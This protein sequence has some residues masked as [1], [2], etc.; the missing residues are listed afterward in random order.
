MK[1]RIYIIFVLCL[2]IIKSDAALKIEPLKIHDLKKWHGLDANSPTLNFQFINKFELGLGFAFANKY[3]SIEKGI[4]DIQGIFFDA[5]INVGIHK[6]GLY[7]RYFLGCE[8]YTDQRLLGLIKIGNKGITQIYRVEFGYLTNYGNDKS[9]F[10]RPQIGFS[11]FNALILY[12]GYN[13]TLKGNNIFKLSND[14]IGNSI[15]LTFIFRPGGLYTMRSG[16]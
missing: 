6:G 16:W 5:N 8:Y 9:L 3:G 7:N 2:I 14:L 1:A 12:V 15:D 10:V 11:L 13:K 4:Q